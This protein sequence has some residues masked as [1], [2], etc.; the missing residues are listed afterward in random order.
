MANFP[1]ANV[2]PFDTWTRLANEYPM[3]T[4]PKFADGGE[5]T[6]L[7]ATTP[8]RK[9]RVTYILLTVAEAAILD[10]WF[11]AN[12]GFHSAFNFTDRDTTVY[13]GVKCVEYERGHGESYTVTQF[14]TILFEDRP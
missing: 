8:I 4:G 7:S 14:R 5:D 2:P 10:A 9:W 13:G 11:D 1:P 12:F 6:F 3:V